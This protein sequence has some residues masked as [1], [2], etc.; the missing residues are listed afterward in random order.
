MT[1]LTDP[2]TITNKSGIPMI[3]VT[4]GR[5]R[6]KKNA[7]NRWEKVGSEEYNFTAFNDTATNLMMVSPGEVIDVEGTIQQNTY[8]TQYKKGIKSNNFIIDKFEINND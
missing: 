3:K 1:V 5:D 6:F 4:L 8:D 2:E 7:Q